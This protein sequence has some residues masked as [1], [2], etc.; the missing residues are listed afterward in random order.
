MNTQ[1]LTSIAIVAALALVGA[2]V[3]S[4]AD[5]AFGQGGPKDKPYGQCKHDFPGPDK[6]CKKFNTGPDH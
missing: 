4:T 2:A 6:V 3:V 1:L 5:V